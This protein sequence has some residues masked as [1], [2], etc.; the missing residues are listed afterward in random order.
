MQ[1]SELSP[2]LP[3][4]KLD[5]GQAEAI[6]RL[7]FPAV[8]PILPELL[9]WL[10]DINWPVAQVFLPLL[11]SIGAP[12]H[13]HIKKILETDDGMWKYWVL[14]HVVAQSRELQDLL[15]VELD[16]ISH[17]PKPDEKE[18]GVDEIVREILG[19]R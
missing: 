14:L 3:K 19:S 2:L 13:L 18:D 7:G 10:Q 4:S 9:E 8:A 11:A 5:T 1:H 16:Q 17:H 12:L 15:I 6:V